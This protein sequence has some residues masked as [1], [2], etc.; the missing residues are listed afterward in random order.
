[1]DKFELVF[2]IIVIAILTSFLSALIYATNFGYQPPT[3]CSIYP[4][5]QAFKSGIE[6]IQPGIYKVRVIA[7]RFYFDPSIIVLKNPKKVIFEVLSRDVIHGFEIVGTNVN[8]MIMPYYTA[9]FTWD[10]PQDLKGDFLIVCNEYC[11]EGHQIMY[12]HLIIER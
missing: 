6:E 4:A 3:V 10:V 9:T 11:G 2:V 12:A 1:M 5:V 8:V 7:E